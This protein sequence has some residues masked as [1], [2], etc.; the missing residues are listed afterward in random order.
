MWNVHK[1]LKKAEKATLIRKVKQ[2]RGADPLRF[3]GR[4]VQIHKLLR[5]CKENKISPQTLD[6]A[7]PHSQQ[8]RLQ[9]PHDASSR[10]D[11]ATLELQSL[12]QSPSQPSQP[13]AMYGDMRTAEVIV[14]NTEIYMN[15][16]FTTGLGTRYFKV[17]PTVVAREE[18]SGQS[19]VLVRNEGAW[20]GVVNPYMIYE[21]VFEAMAALEWGFIE[22]AFESIDK[23]YGLVQIL[24]EQE[25]P[26]LLSYL[27][28]IFVSQAK[29]DSTFERNVRQFILD[30][31][32]T[33]LGHAHP[34]SKI[35]SSLCIVASTNEKIHVWRIMCEALSKFFG[36]LEDP[37]PLRA[38]R[39]QCMYGLR[40]NGFLKESEHYF[41]L[42]YENMEEQNP[43]YISEK[44]FFLEN[45]GNYTEAEILNRKCLEL[46]KEAEYEI[47]END[48]T[49][50]SLEWWS[51][52]D[53]CQDGLARV[54]EL[55]GRI[56]ES[57]AIRWRNLHFISAAMGPDSV[58]FEVTV[59]GLDDF[60][61]KQGYSE[62][63]AELKAQYPCLL[64][65][66]ELPQESL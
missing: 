46:M 32:K 62:E 49:S 39:E 27:V 34:L 66:K 36:A 21:H 42:L 40:K 24:F 26:T 61:Q 20:N 48:T 2:T 5:Y 3:K 53:V 65:R 51:R 56:D 37:V 52:I 23:A 58:D 33:V 59:S 57:K 63:S 22:S 28:D 10:A 29:G 9:S 50:N 12:F 6:T 31:A 14:W 19:L 41:Y 55:T 7:T 47:L 18:V 43:T 17:K 25:A 30:M 35:L 16:Y 11:S 8:Q 38:T 1:N 54:L 45:Q 4:P 15:S 60:L 44:A 64:R 13:V